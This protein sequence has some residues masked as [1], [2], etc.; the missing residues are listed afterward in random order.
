MELTIKNNSQFK[1]GYLYAIRLLAAS[2]KSEREVS[3]R[4]EEKGYSKETI[5]QVLNELISQKIL[6]DQKL[7]GETIQN[8]IHAKRYGRRRIF[9][10][11]KKRGIPSPEIEKA[12]ED[13][14][15]TLERETAFGLARD[16]WIKLE[17]VEYQKRKKRLYDFLLNRGF[18][19]E[20]AREIVNQMRSDINENI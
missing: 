19:F 3:K 8:A 20:L 15:K 13:Y 11:L 14:P 17:K 6:S 5:N 18:D 2:K 12:L 7:V 4:L 9:M 10:E 1:Q 16:R